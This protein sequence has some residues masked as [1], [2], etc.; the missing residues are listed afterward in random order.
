M[1]EITIQD[2]FL[3]KP[4]IDQLQY[5]FFQM[6]WFYNRSVSN[7]GDNERQFYHLFYNNGNSNSD[8]IDLLKPF[9]SHFDPAA[10]LRI[11]ANLLP[12]TSAIKIFGMH[13]DFDFKCTTA[14][15]YVNS[16]NGFTYFEDGTR[17]ESVANRLVTFPSHMRHTGTTCTDEHDRI[18]INF[19]YLKKEPHI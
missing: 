13:T 11:K 12:K 1:S 10:L 16:N 17:I 9:I 15:F 3:I 2:D 4:L 8:K 5:E 6:P 18:V 7:K 14:I 19:N